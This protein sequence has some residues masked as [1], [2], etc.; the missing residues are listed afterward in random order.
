MSGVVLIEVLWLRPVKDAW[1]DGPGVDAAGDLVEELGGAG[2]AEAVGS[3]PVAS[4]TVAKLRW[5]ASAEPENARRVATVVLPHDW[6]TWRLLD[7]PA[8]AVTDRGDASGTG[9]W[10]P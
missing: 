6:L 9:Y 4:L 1:E 8:E 10:S 7:R 5:L 2:W 3:V